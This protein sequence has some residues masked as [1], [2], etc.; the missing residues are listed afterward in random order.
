MGLDIKGL[1]KSYDKILFENVNLD[2]ERGEI[3]AILG[4]SGCGKST[5]LRIVC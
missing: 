5:L 1:T 4:N 2:I 3:V